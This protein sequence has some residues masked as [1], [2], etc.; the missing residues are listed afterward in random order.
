MIYL[1]QR[2]ILNQYAW[3]KPSPGR[4]GAAGEGDYVK[5][6]GFGHEDWNFNYELAIADHIFGY[7]YYEPI[8]DK[9]AE[10]FQF[11]FATYQSSRWY[12]AGF[13]LDTT[14][15]PDGPP[16]DS[17]VLKEKARHLLELKALNSLGKPWSSL[18]EAEIIRKLEKEARWLRWKVRVKNAIRLPVPIEIPHRIYNTRNYHLTRPQGISRSTFDALRQL[19]NKTVLPEDDDEAAFPEGREL[20]LKHRARERNPAVVRHAKTLFLRR[21]G[22]FFCQA[23][24]FDFERV[25]GELGRGVIEA[26]HT[27]PVSEL[28]SGAKTKVSDIALICPNCHRMVHRKRPWLTI[29]QLQTILK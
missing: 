27:T 21:H 18:T 8:S 16:P 1:V 25:Y 7:A 6:N 22:R 29:N 26:H 12:L 5:E 28:S 19:S 17:R 14:F 15:A 11:V 10:L 9:K 3:T 20:F 23:C 13:Y 4:I 24:G 2:L